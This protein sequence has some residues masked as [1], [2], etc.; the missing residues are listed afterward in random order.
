MLDF[1]KEALETIEMV[2]DN[3]LKE[4]IGEIQSIRPKAV[5]IENIFYN[6]FTELKG[7]EKGQI[8]KIKYQTNKKN[9][10][11][12]KNI[13]AIELMGGKVIREH[14][15]DKINDTTVN[16]LIMTAKELYLDEIKQFT[17]DM[18]FRP[19][20]EEVLKDVFES[21]NKVMRGKI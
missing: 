5:A 20:F 6:S 17:A 16:T 7:Y 12:F 15:L 3:Q 10:K 2:T 1:V 4:I 21:Y 13:K 11:E 19:S 9:N 18:E 14:D 8:V